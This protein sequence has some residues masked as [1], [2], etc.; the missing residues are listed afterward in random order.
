MVVHQSGIARHPA[1]LARWISVTLT[2]T[3]CGHSA[4]T[5]STDS[6]SPSGTRPAQLDGVLVSPMRERWD[7]A[8]DEAH[9]LLDVVVLGGNVDCVQRRRY[10]PGRE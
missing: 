6:T 3:Y 1:R 9:D 5:S 2:T 8:I 7:V 4:W 10:R